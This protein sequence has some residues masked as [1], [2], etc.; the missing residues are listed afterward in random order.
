MNIFKK[1]LYKLTNNNTNKFPY[2]IYCD[3][4]GVLVD[5][6]ENGV[7][8]TIKN[9]K[10]QDIAR[11]IVKNNIKWSKTHSNKEIES[12]LEHIRSIVA[13]NIVFWAN[14][15]PLP[16]AKA[17][18]SYISQYNVKILSHPWDNLCIEGKKIWLSN[19]LD[20]KPAKRDIFLPLKGN[21]ERWAVTNG[22]PNVLIDDFEQYLKPWREAGGIAIHHTS[23]ESTIKA[24]EEL[25]TNY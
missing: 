24:L 16:D 4:D 12:V 23:A 14:L 17:L 8:S 6:F 11:L 1:L 18:W 13:N 7:Y 15:K 22:K 10:N 19:N 9:P 25:K 20:P 3:M 21:K 2:T 5:L